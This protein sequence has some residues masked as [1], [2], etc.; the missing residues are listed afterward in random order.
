MPLEKEIG[1]AIWHWRFPRSDDPDRLEE[2][3][4]CIDNFPDSPFVGC[5]KHEIE[6]IKWVNGWN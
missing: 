4:K 6:Y 3:Q 2:L 5:W 1:G